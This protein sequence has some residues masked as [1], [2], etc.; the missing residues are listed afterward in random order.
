MKPLRI[1]V[2]WPRIGYMS[3]NSPI[4]SVRSM[5]GRNA[6]LA[7]C[8]H[9]FVFCILKS[10]GNIIPLHLCSCVNMWGYVHISKHWGAFALPLLSLNSNKYYI[11]WVCVC[12]LIYVAFKAH[13]QYY[14]VVCGLSG[15]CIFP[16]YLIK[17]MMFGENWNWTLKV[18]VLVCCATFVWNS[19]RSKKNWAR[20]D[21]KCTLVRHSI[22]QLMHINCKILRLL[23]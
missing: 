9:V 1:P 18:F 16:H 12:S 11:F 10:V 3:K 14:I 23:K 7:G 21:Q 15:C 4:M 5:C 13:A 20:Y 19:S 22:S 8:R 6:Y 2:H 17:G